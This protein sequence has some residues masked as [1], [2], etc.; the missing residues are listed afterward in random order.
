MATLSK[1][2]QFSKNFLL[3]IIVICL[4]LG[5]LEIASYFY[6]RFQ[7]YESNRYN[8]AQIVSGYYVFRN[9]PGRS[10]WKEVK[11]N[12][13]DPPTVVDFNG[14]VSDNPITLNKPDNTYRI[15]LM[16]GSAVFGIGQFPPFAAVHPYHQGYLSYSLGPA[17]QLERYLQAQRPDMQFEVINAA[18][19]DRTLHQSMLYYLE[20]VS[21][22]SPDMVINVDGYNDL[23][24]GLMS[25]RHYAEIE[26]RLEHYIDL[27]QNARTYRPHFMNVLMLGYNEFLQP[28][29]NQR[30]K[31]QFYFEKDLDSEIYSLAAYKQHEPAFIQSSQRFLQILEHYMAVLKADRVDFMFT[32]QPQLYRQINKQWSPIEDRMRRT[33]FGIGPNISPEKIDRYILM[34]KYFFDHYLSEA[35]EARLVGQNYGFMDLNAEI[36]HLTSDFELYVDYCHFTKQGS[37][38]VAEL[39]GRDVLKRLPASAQGQL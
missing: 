20:T 31:E 1:F 15:F 34:S 10:F 35:S 16:G 5:G 26:S 33:V 9:T 36:R 8:Y 17:G 18:T 29:V 38:T 6:L 28:M 32:L 7:G 24:F 19:S 14:F 25:G 2:E 27:L 3:S 21:R 30:L 39:I 12:P 4:V 13:S 22:F 37:Q 11:E 23:Y